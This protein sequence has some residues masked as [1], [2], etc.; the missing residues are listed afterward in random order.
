M[1]NA[2]KNA[3]NG[4]KEKFEAW[5]K[6]MGH[7][8]IRVSAKDM[9][10]QTATIQ[11]QWEGWKAGTDA[12]HGAY[13]DDL[14]YQRDRL[15][16]GYYEQ[17]QKLTQRYEFLEKQNAHLIRLIMERNNLYASLYPVQGED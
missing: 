11:A 9:D 15:E 5:Q 3:E 8:P 6:S 17:V 2:E 7:C 14:A 12:L 16:K 1:S 10:Y 4:L 13:C